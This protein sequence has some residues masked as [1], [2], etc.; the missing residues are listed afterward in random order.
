MART[1]AQAAAAR[2]DWPRAVEA[3]ALKRAAILKASR[4][5]RVEE[6]EIATLEREVMHS[7]RAPFRLPAMLARATLTALP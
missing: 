3:S 5:L 4:K 2:A 1:K 7:T 6:V